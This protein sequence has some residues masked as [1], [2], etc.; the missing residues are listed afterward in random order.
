M[1]KHTINETKNLL[2]EDLE[3]LVLQRDKEKTSY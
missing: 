3:D 2:L 1:K